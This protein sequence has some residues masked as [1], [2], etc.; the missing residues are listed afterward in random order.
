M[1]I[2]QM[3]ATNTMASDDLFNR[4][5]EN[6]DLNFDGREFEFEDG[7][8]DDLLSAEAQQGNLTLDDFDLQN[9]MDS[10]QS[11]AAGIGKD[12]S[13]LS[14][15]SQSSA[16]NDKLV[17]MPIFEVNE[18][19]MGDIFMETDLFNS[20]NQQGGEFQDSFQK[21]VDEAIMSGSVDDETL[22]ATQYQQ[23]IMSDTAALEAEKAELL[24]KLSQF[25]NSN[26]SNNFYSNHNGLSKQN[27]GFVAQKTNMFLSPNVNVVPQK[28]LVVSSLASV[29]STSGETPL[30]SFLRGSRKS[31]C[32]SELQPPRSV[33][34]QNISGAP[35]A[36]S[37][38][39][40]MHMNMETI[41]SERELL[42]NSSFL[43]DE[44]SNFGLF[45]SMDRSTVS[46]ELV[47]KLSEKNLMRNNSGHLV[48]QG[49]GRSL[50][51]QANATWGMN[52][53]DGRKPGGYKTSGILRK[54]SSET[55]L[56]RKGLSP[57]ANKYKISS[58]ISRE[59]LAYSLLKKTPS[60]RN[61][62]SLGNL[63]KN[64]SFA[65]MPTKRSMPSAKH[66]LALS[67]SVPHMLRAGNRSMSPQG[68][69]Q[70]AKW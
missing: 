30:Q 3:H 51:G 57:S 32:E 40:R 47:K 43:R 24:S 64:D 27:D 52:G 25:A 5:I 18:D 7:D 61:L 69:Q 50:N 1:M 35:N 6:L 58:G 28:N 62:G 68:F 59:N 48:R 44:D 23:P 10:E 2:D 42:G 39:S 19:K 11:A 67:S 36:A 54:H 12:P 45:S 38:F 66:R 31:M 37:V 63:A 34:S 13:A 65:D 55:H 60:G 46:N 26:Q 53:D 56:L 8:Y 15:P 9:L 17:D 33:L 70:N 4:K 22:Q 49:S 14:A 20:G 21:M 29:H 41:E 16:I